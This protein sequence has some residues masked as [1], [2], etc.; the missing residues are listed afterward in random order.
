MKQI[1]VVSGKGGTG[2]T[3]LSGSLSF[4]FENHVMAD[5]DVDA[6]NLHLLMEPKL[7]ETHEY[8]GGKKA[9]IDDRCTACGICMNTCRFSAIIPGTPYKVDPYACEGCNACVLTCPEGAITLKESKSGDYFLSK[10][11]E[12]SLSHALLTPGEETSGGLIAEVRKLALKVAEQEKRDYVIIDGAPGIGC[13]ASSSITGVNYV[14][15]VAEPT[16]SG[17]HD[18]QR[19]VETTR[20]FMRKFGIVINKFDLNTVKADEIVNWCNKE[21]IEI[22]GKIPFDPEVRN[23]AI[24]AEPVVK[25]GDSPAA[26]AIRKIYY[27]LLKI[28]GGVNHEVSDTCD[29]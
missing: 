29:E 5:C 28:I 17:M 1:A 15:I 25:S 22:L 19:I 2:K 11:A 26:K 3:T 23:S 14:I 18:L 24:R 10:A 27:K 12:L 20:H 7:L 21:K 9:E 16:I 4:L 6:P 8:F 13:A